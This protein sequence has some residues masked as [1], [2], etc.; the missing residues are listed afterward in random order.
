MTTEDV[1]RAEVEECRGILK[2]YRVSPEDIN[3]ITG[4]IEQ[5]YCMLSES[6]RTTNALEAYAKDELGEGWE[7][8][9]FDKWMTRKKEPG[10]NLASYMVKIEEEF[11]KK[12]RFTVVK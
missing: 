5:A 1:C 10:K 9:F 6:Y 4:M 8:D 11:E 3:V 7:M 12:T 2:K